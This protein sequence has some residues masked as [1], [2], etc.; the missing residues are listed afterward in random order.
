MAAG[1]PK[2]KKASKTAKDVV[3]VPVE[4]KKM[5]KAKTDKKVAKPA[6]EA[7]SEPAAAVKKADKKVKRKRSEEEDN[8]ADTAVTV[9]KPSKTAKTSLASD[10]AKKAAGIIVSEAKSLNDFPTLSEAIK[11]ILRSQGIETLF[12][13]QAMTLDYG[14]QGEI[15]GC[16]HHSTTPFHASLAAVQLLIKQRGL[17]LRPLML[18][19]CRAGHGWQGAHWLWQ[20]ARVCAAHRGAAPPGAAQRHGHGRAHLWPPAQRPRHGSHS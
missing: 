10:A 1:D 7:G 4:A 12:A 9:E 6:E 18:S 3:E 15:T 2:K 14:I 8:S 13:I 11:S 5:K 16:Y 20:D 19:A 17:E